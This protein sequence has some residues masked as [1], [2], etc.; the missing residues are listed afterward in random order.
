M[1]GAGTGDAAVQDGLL[2]SLVKA[3]L[4]AVK[5]RAFYPPQH[6]TVVQGMQELSAALA[7]LLAS[8]PEIV[9]GVIGRDLVVDGRPLLKDSPFFER[10]RQ[11]LAERAVEKLSLRPGIRDEDLQA[12]VEALSQSPE[13][14]REQGG[15]ERFLSGRGVRGIQVSRFSVEEAAPE[16]AGEL[17]EQARA[18]YREGI[19]GVRNLTEKFRAEAPV[20]ASEVRQITSILIKGLQ[21]QRAPMLAALALRQKSAYTFSHSLN[22]SLLVLAQVEMLDLTER[23]LE[24]ITSA[25]LLHDVGKLSVPEEILEKPGPLT[26]AEWAIMRLHPV[27]GVE[28]LRRMQDVSDLALIVAFEHHLRYDAAGYP[29]RRMPWPMNHLSALTAVADTY[30]AMR[31]RRPYDPPWP[32]EKVY[33]TMMGIAGKSLHPGLLDRFFRI[34]GVYPPGT[35]VRLSTGA[36]GT[37]LRNH[38]AFHDRPVVQVLRSPGGELLERPP[39]V[40]L[41]LERE[42]HGEEATVVAGSIPEEAAAPSPGR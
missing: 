15:I 37:I 25:S 19:D 23:Q 12:F 17:F 4:A 20:S 36:E 41:A 8:A 11:D 31:S 21:D 29:P 30:D 39:V 18:T 16:E 9:I 42:L 35:P 2:R 24:E 22:V 3:L 5:N 26:D 27:Y 14:L 6:P 40:D 34:V 13:A 38:P 28:A 10:F 32:C 1:S 33:Q 7:A